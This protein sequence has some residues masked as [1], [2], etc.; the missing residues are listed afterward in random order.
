[1]KKILAV[2]ILLAVSLSLVGCGRVYTSCTA[3]ILYN[4]NGEPVQVFVYDSSLNLDGQIYN[5]YQ[6]D[7]EYYVNAKINF[8]ISGKVKLPVTGTIEVNGT[9]G[10]SEIGKIFDGSASID[11]VP[12]DSGENFYQGE[13]VLNFYYLDT[14]AEYP[15]AVL[16]D[17]FEGEVLSVILSPITYTD[18]NEYIVLSNDEGEYIY[19]PFDMDDPDTMLD[20]MAGYTTPS[21][22]AFYYIESLEYDENNNPV[23]AE[24]ISGFGPIGIEPS[25]LPEDYEIVVDDSESSDLSGVDINF[26]VFGLKG[27]TLSVHT[28]DNGIMYIA[29]PDINGGYIYVAF[30]FDEVGK[31]NFGLGDAIVI[32]RN[33][34]DQPE[35]TVGGNVVIKPFEP[36]S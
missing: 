34:V 30:D 1:M 28:T 36:L 13:P 29:I 19:V 31:G 27:L 5:V 15:I 12:A 16:T 25:A 7:G 8:D 10:L 11:F 4:E 20:R 17:S 23:S 33:I 6:E 26:P 24:L 35:E 22:K 21:E 9:A 18:G 32:P 3:Q 2:F 14:N